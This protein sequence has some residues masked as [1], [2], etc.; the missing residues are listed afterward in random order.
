MSKRILII[1]PFPLPTT[2]VSLANQVVAKYLGNAQ[3][4][5]I[6]SLN[7]SYSSFDEKLGRFSFK[8]MWF[9]LSLNLSLHKVLKADIIYITPGQTFFGV[10]KYT[11][12][13][14]LASILNKSLVLHIHG[15]YL[16]KQYE[17]L[18][19]PKRKVFHNLMSRTSTGIVLSE[20]LVP[21]FKPF[22]AEDKIHILKN[23]VIDELFFEQ[24]IMKQKNFKTLKIVYLSNLM[25]EKGILDLLQALEILEQNNINYEAQIAGNIAL[26]NEEFILSKLAKLQF[27][28]YIG[29]VNVSQ[30]VALFKWSN[31]FVLPTYYTMEGQPIS[32]LEAMA[33]GN[34][35][36]TTN[37]AGIPDM[38][39]NGKNGFFVEKKNPEDIAVKLTTLNNQTSQIETIAISNFEEAKREYSVDKFIGRLKDI[40]SHS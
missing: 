37:H 1:G 38:F 3:E 11:V 34:V 19:G 22:I 21:N 32:I 16:G 2:G 12:F 28:Q 6:T 36:L 35:I 4:Y 23:F 8:K 29:I 10:L 7:T 26:E 5:T 17:L 24:D 15:N 33:T 27:T 9:Y 14:V 39:K 30:K 13:I 25:V 20:S 40:L 18:K 31:V